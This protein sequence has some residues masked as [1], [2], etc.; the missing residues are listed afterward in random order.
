MCRRQLHQVSLDPQALHVNLG[1]LKFDIPQRTLPFQGGVA[2]AADDLVKQVTTPVGGGPTSS[3]R[4]STGPAGTT[5]NTGT[6]VQ[7]TTSGSAISVQVTESWWWLCV[8]TTY[9][10]TSDF[11]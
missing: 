8:V 5:G 6:G 7:P 3:T 9:R 11:H 1:P 4:P 10:A 2:R